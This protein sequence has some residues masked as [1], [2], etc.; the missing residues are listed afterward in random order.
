MNKI[1]W[2]LIAPFLLKIRWK[3][4]SLNIFNKKG[5]IDLSI[6]KVENI[7]NKKYKIIIASIRSLAHS[8]LFEGAIGKAL[9][10][11]GY[12]VKV[13]RCGQYL[14]N[15]ETK[16]H[17]KNNQ[18]TCSM[19]H[20]EFS[21]FQ[22]TF[23]LDSIEYA[24]L[25]TKEERIEI[26]QFVRKANLNKV[27]EWKGINIE[28]EWHSALQRYYLS[29]NM[30]LSSKPETARNF[31]F[32]VIIN[33]QS[34]F[35]LKELGF[36]HLFTSHGIYS[37]WGGIIAGFNEAGG[38]VSVWG[39]GYYKSGI[40][41]FKNESYLNGLKYFIRNDFVNKLRIE[42]IDEIKKYLD[43]RW[44][45]TNDFD[46]VKYYSKNDNQTNDLE[47]IIPVDKFIIGFYPNI[48]WDGQ[49]FVATENFKGLRDVIKALIKYVNSNEDVHVV[50]RPHPYE[51]PNR[52]PHIGERF[53]DLAKEYGI[54]KS[55]KFTIIPYDSSIT[56]YDVAKISKVNVLLA[57]TIGLEFAVRGLPVVQLGENIASNKGIFLEPSNYTEFEI[58]LNNLIKN[59]DY[60]FNEN[61][62][63]K[64]ALE[65]ATFF[66]KQV[67][68]PDFFFFNKGT[69]ITGVKSQSET[70]QKLLRS[71]LE[72]ILEGDQLFY[73]D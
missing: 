47:K 42:K 40:I 30:H 26:D 46:L 50:V 70:D 68:I 61:E 10:D 3:R 45:L 52:N 51:N 73:L 67:H 31:L 35:K 1:I 33:I 39:R 24:D 15:C 25:I 9:Q 69:K 56:S 37:T 12:E 17:F 48:P 59:V 29:P 44:S 38:N 14:Q 19:C 18:M 60:H 28:K 64:N 71:Y 36:T 34:G 22:K 57:G 2:N 72:W 63:K 55:V 16:S 62:T 13:L 27:K 41:S 65:W 53:L 23:G 66:Y 58:I 54:D 5:E 32:T 49:V 4:V 7:E 43:S 20:K 6:P 8:N 21:Y 11:N